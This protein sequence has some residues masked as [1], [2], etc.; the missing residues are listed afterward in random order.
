MSVLKAV[1]RACC[2]IAMS[3]GAAMLAT[4]RAMGPVTVS[5]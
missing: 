4:I 1:S 3:G 2:K 5:D